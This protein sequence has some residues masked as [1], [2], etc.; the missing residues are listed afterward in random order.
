MLVTARREG[1]AFRIGE[2]VE[3]K[4][5]EIHRSK[6]IVGITAPASVRVQRLETI[7]V[8]QENIAASRPPD[9]IIDRLKNAKTGAISL[10]EGRPLR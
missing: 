9:R 10:S 6:V 4:I 2:D 3:I 1:Q 8:Q 5:L 7:E